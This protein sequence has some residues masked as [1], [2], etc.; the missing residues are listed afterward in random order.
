MKTFKEI[1]TSKQKFNSDCIS[2]KALN[3]LQKSCDLQ[4]LRHFI[5]PQMRPFV[6]AI[7]PSRRDK[8]ELLFTFNNYPACVE[9]NKFHAKELIK[10]I[11]NNEIL[12]QKTQTQFY[13]KIRGYVP[14]KQ[15]EP[16]KFQEI[17]ENE[18]YEL[19]EGSFINHAKNPRL[20]EI[21]EDIRAIIRLK[22]KHVQNLKSQCMQGSPTTYNITQNPYKTTK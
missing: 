1:L 19:A 13:T 16:Y 6:I 5:V 11:K 18:L 8:K 17:A 14:K 4:L 21:F 10:I 15:L 22:H 9:F 20:H 3:F 2:N 7:T 12:Q